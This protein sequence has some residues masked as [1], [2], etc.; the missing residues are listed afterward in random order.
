M[1]TIPDKDTIYIDIDDE[2]TVMIDKLQSSQAKIVALVLPKRATVLQSIVNMKL[3]KRAADS[4]SK[5]LVLITS[6]P[7]L[8]PLAGAASVYV[9][10]NLQSKPEVPTNPTSPVEDEELSA[11]VPAETKAEKEDVDKTKSVG[12]LAT[13]TSA[14]PP[15]EDT[16]EVDNDTDEEVSAPTKAAGA[17]AVTKAA[18]S[19]AKK[20]TKNK[21]PN[22]ERFRKRLFLGAAALILLIVFWFLAV[23]TLPKATIVI[24]TDTSSE[25]ASVNFTASPGTTTVDVEKSVMPA[26]LASSAKSDVQ[27]A[28]ASGQKDAGAKASGT[29]TITNCAN[30]D[31][32]VIPGGSAF[33]ANGKTFL[34]NQSVTVPGA[35][36][37]GGSCSKAGAATVGVTANENGDSYNI[38]AANYASSTVPDGA[39]AQGSAMS[40][41][42]TKIV[43]AV[44]QSDVDSAKGKL[45][46]GDDVAKE[47]L[48][49]SLLD[50]GYTPLLDTFGIKDAATTVSPNVGEEGAEVTVSS[51]GTYTMLGIK[52]D[53]L[54]KIVEKSVQE[55]I[56][57]DKQQVQD[58]GLSAATFKLVKSQP[59]AEATLSVDTTVAIGPKIDESQLKQQVAGMKRGETENTIKALPGVKDV[60]VKYSPFWVSKTPKKPAKIT[61]VFEKAN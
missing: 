48:K 41:G 8:L 10:K 59:G 44:T 19:K 3:L 37:S 55:Q 39:T 25:Q 51:K 27:K 14:I 58:Y 49:K 38:A 54:K 17:A 21:I 57:S 42:V 11:E 50:E 46:N 15:P 52:E 36:F 43:K 7:G 1:S 29:M 23:F 40:G 35:K 24:K 5:N 22:F 28:P 56:D 12:E 30:S 31:S 2:I 18:K 26:K 53:D 4:A 61:M 32:F 47:A 16:I 6:E 33:V 34:S 9:A 45:T 20:D 13:K 60:Q